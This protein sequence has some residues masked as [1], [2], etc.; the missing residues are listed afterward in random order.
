[1]ASTKFRFYDY[2]GA[3]DYKY[4]ATCTVNWEV[5]GSTIKITSFNYNRDPNVAGWYV[6]SSMRL[7]V[8]WEGDSS[9]TVICEGTYNLDA[10]VNYRVQ[11]ANAGFITISGVTGI[12]S[13]ATSRC[14]ISK[15]FSNGSKAGFKI[16]FGSTKGTINYGNPGPYRL[17]DCLAGVSGGGGDVPEVELDYRPGERL[18]GS[19][20]S[21]NRDGGVCERS[22]GGWV[23]MRTVAGTGRPP[24]ICSGGSWK[25]QAKLE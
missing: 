25:N 9:P 23:E 8:Q 18:S 1:M 3:S 24:E 17:M 21:L 19:W 16:W 22:A 15:T 20:L 4:T 11:A 5:S 6:G 13:E 10:N 2:R 12:F 14:P 7:G